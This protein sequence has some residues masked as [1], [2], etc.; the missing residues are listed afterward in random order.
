[1]TTVKKAIKVLGYNGD[2]RSWRNKIESEQCYHNALRVADLLDSDGVE[3]VEGY[4]LID[5]E[6]VQHAWNSYNGEYF[7]LTYQIHFKRGMQCERKEVVRGTLKQLQTVGYL[8][9]PV[10]ATLIEQKEK[11]GL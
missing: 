8:L 7:D 5:D 1:M 11:M 6:W 4:V 9:D 10:F 2:A 3:Y